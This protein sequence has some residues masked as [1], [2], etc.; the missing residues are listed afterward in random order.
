M[1]L[2]Y[3]FILYSLPGFPYLGVPLFPSFFKYKN[4]RTHAVQLLKLGFSTSGSPGV[5]IR[6][7]GDL[8]ID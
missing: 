7:S 4:V 1:F 6:R 8:R 2:P 3:Y 5:D